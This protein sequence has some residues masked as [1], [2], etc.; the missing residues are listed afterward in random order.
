M[1]QLMNMKLLNSILS[2]QKE[3][4]REYKLRKNDYINKSV[5]H[6]NVES[7]VEDGWS[8][9]RKL[10]TK[11]RLKKIKPF[12]ERLENK[13]W[14]LLFKLGYQDLNQG[15]QF[16]ISFKRPAGGTGEKQIDVFAKD[17]GTVIIAE[18]KASQKIRTRSL[19]KDIE[20][21]ANLQKPIATSVKKFYGKGFKPKILWLFV[22]ENILWRDS[23][24]KRAEG[25]NIKR[26]S[27]R[28]LRYFNQIA[29]HLGHSARYQF[30]AEFFA[31]Q[32]IPELEGK[33]I[34]AIRGK[35]GG[36]KM[37][38]FVSTPRQLLR[39]SFVNHRSLKD[40]EGIPTYQRLV[41]KNRMKSIGKFI[42]EGGFFPN[43]ILINFNHKV[44]FDPS[45]KDDDAGVHF[46][47]LHFPNKYKSAWVID[48]QH[49]LYGFS[50]ADETH[51][52]QNII[53]TAFEKMSH[54][55][56][57][58]LFVTINHE[59]KSVQRTLLDDLK[60]A[61]EW[62]STV[63]TKRIG[64]ISSRL[65]G[66][67]NDDIGGPFYTRITAQGIKA[68]KVSCLTLP[69][70]MDGLRHSALIGKATL[71]KK[72]YERGPLCDVSDETT[73]QRAR[74]G[75]NQ[76]F[77]IIKESSPDRWD[78]GAQRCLCSNASIQAF[79]RL[80][81][82]LVVYYE[83]KNSLDTRE[84][85]IDAL[86]LGVQPY[87]EPV[88]S[89]IKTANEDDF[90]EQFKVKYGAGGPREYFFRLCRL[91]K[92][93]EAD[94]SPEGY[95]DWEL[96][97]SEEKIL[98]ADKQIQEINTISVSYIFDKFKGIYGVNDN[99][100]WENGVSN[101]NMKSDA[102]TRSLEYPIEERG[103]LENY[104]DFLD[105]KKIIEKKEHWSHFKNVFNIPLLGEKGTAKNL[106]W[107]EKINELRRIQAHKT[108]ERN[109]KPEDFDYICWVHKTLLEKIELD[110]CEV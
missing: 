45:H 33:T 18:C 67:L 84:M 60:G 65:I 92:S 14:C 75:L 99:A 83:Q 30:L 93:S 41:Q 81:A 35:L 19:Q 61:L 15:R 95:E 68:T 110:E 59:Q 8:F 32:K 73:L 11:T 50:A 4:E 31:N 29:D 89:F 72:I 38:T 1:D 69:S 5:A 48:G 82:S 53:V 26:I 100:Y 25:E 63:P 3:R 79:M 39:I 71:K 27:E 36:R 57:A 13:F 17:D 78:D 106:K 77:T 98:I 109:Y 107:M 104:L 94:F 90:L 76:Y 80:L 51:L 22:T 86:L 55:D 97:Q 24:L 21:F 64:A 103:G 49:R 43:N 66:L 34:P 6:Q 20:E 74:A 58:K 47:T 10:S 96:S 62:G 91:V 88:L 23:D 2:D 44:N 37:Y 42:D 9:D 28:E 7:Y 56:E 54:E 105:L 70:L 101:K 40:P 87:L 52:D 108:N 12:D 46:G 16:K 102:Y 85:E